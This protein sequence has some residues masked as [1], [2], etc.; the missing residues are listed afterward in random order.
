METLWSMSTTIREAERIVGFAKTAVEL[1]GQIWNKDCQKKFQVL[2]IKNR[3]YLYDPDNTQNFNKLNSQQSALLR[4][5]SVNMTYEQALDIFDAKDY[6][7]PP[8]RGRQSMAPLQK[9]GLVYIVNEDGNSVVKTTEVCKK[10]VNGEI[11]F[12]DFMLD[13]LLKFQYPNPYEEGF[14][15]WNTKPFINTLRLIKK[16]NE[17]CEQYGKKA[18]GISTLEFG[19]FALSLKSYLSVDA[20]AEKIV[21]FREIYDSFSDYT[22]RD[23]FVEKYINEYLSEFKNPVKNVKEYTDNMVRYLR[24]TKYIYIRGKYSNTY[25]D[26]EPRRM[27]EINSILEHD[28]GAAKDYTA[29]EWVEYMGTYGTYE[30]PFE[31]VTVLSTILLEINNEIADLEVGLGLFKTQQ[32]LPT[33]KNDLIAEIAQRREYR[34][35]LQNIELKNM[36]RGSIDKIEEAINSLKDIS[37]R[38][39]Q[40]KKLSIELEKWTNI[41]LNIIN[42]AELIKPNSPVGDDNEPIY[43]AP[44]GVADIECYYES[45]NA[46]TEVTMLTSRD[47]WYNEG[48]PVMRHLR[49]FEKCNNEK[50]N[51]CLFIAPRLHV[52]TVNTFYTSVKYEYEGKRQKII[53]ITIYQLIRL[54]EIVKQKIARGEKFSHKVLQQFYDECTDFSAFRNSTEW[55]QVIEN[56]ISNLE[57][58][59]AV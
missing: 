40:D 1:D 8:M 10:L 41:A 21:K 34:T 54:L 14:K 43:T 48:Q 36:Y 13:S 3:Q 47:Q 28:T 2:L 15:N 31:K 56:R 29:E 20:V 50:P 19:I 52:D 59:M 12:N 45:F 25:I 42:D 35:Q 37:N 53:P 58:E 30:L 32:T 5:K 18:K 44:S 27:T 38:R 49:E 33:T 39:K 23:S 7:D 6:E 9:L 16:V 46:V 57:L 51:Y 24:L 22:E 4:D 55:Q 26:L 17:L 11:E